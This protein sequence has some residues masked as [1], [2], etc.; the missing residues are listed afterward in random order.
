MHIPPDGVTNEMQVKVCQKLCAMLSIVSTFDTC[1]RDEQLQV[2]AFYGSALL[3]AI[4]L[5]ISVAID[6]FP[7]SLFVVLVAC[8][9]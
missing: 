9:L 2:C 4:P 7:L 1:T 3:S 5:P 8:N 6:T